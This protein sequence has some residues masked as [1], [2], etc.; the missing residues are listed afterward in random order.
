MSELN[1]V[2]ITAMEA[3]NMLTSDQRRE[4]REKLEA[5]KIEQLPRN[6]FYNYQT[7]EWI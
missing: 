1:Q 7:Q 4:L 5:E 6:L 3:I 2:Q